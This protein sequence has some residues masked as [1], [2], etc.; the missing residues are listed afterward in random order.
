MAKPL[1][2]IIQQP[3]T[4]KADTCHWQVPC[5]SV[6]TQ[7]NGGDLPQG[8][9]WP[10]KLN[11][12]QRRYD[13]TQ[14]ICRRMVWTAI[15]LHSSI[16]WDWPTVCAS[17]KAFRQILCLKKWL[18]CWC[19]RYCNWESLL[20]RS[21]PDLEKVVCRPEPYPDSPEMI[22]TILTLMKII[23]SAIGSKR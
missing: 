18:P 6:Q 21:S 23:P 16:E 11:D 19:T 20:A 15:L 17:C 4:I 22:L 3:F 12:R 9:Y 5:L 8:L 13:M 14:W 10:R 1:F 2:S 7:R